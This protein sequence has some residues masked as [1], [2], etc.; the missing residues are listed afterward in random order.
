MTTATVASIARQEACM[1]SDTALKKEFPITF[2]EPRKDAAVVYLD[3]LGFKNYVNTAPAAALQLLIDEYVIL[4]QRVTD[5][6][7]MEEGKVSV[8]DELRDLAV[9]NTVSSFDYLRSLSDSVFIVSY[10]TE[11]LLSQLSNF[12]L[13]CFLFN[14]NSY[15]FPDDPVNPTQVATNVIRK[16]KNGGYEAKAETQTRFPVLLRGGMSF[17][18]TDRVET[19]EIARGDLVKVSNFS[20]MTVVNAVALEKAGKGP[21]IFCDQ[22][23]MD[24]MPSAEKN[25]FLL[26]VMGRK[27][28][29]EVLWP[30]AVFIDANSFDVEIHHFSDLFLP[31]ATFWKAWNHEE[32]GVHY[33]EF[34]KLIIRSTLSYSRSKGCES[35]GLDAMKKVITKTG[36]SDK[37][38]RLTSE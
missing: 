9:Q 16:A 26:P 24:G 18:P 19:H 28:V 38:D 22:A 14:S 34:M 29:Y 1:S 5:Q 31:A 4:N 8:P 32:H 20:S 30:R 23:V 12:V 6:R 27:G 37:M 36:L 35:A 17:G 21:R 2:C 7:M 25:R 3:L 15:A 11:S 10:K 13:S 33:W